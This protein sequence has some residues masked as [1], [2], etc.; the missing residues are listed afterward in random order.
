M[1]Y[2]FCLVL[3][4]ALCLCVCNGPVTDG[5]QGGTVITNG[6]AVRENGAPVE[7]AIVTAYPAGHSPPFPTDTALPQ[8]ITGKDGAFILETVAVLIINLVVIDSGSNSG[9]VL[10]GLT[11]DTAV[12]ALTLARFGTISGTVSGDSTGTSPL[13][14]GCVGTPFFGI[15]ASEG[16]AFVI[17]DIPPGHYNVKIYPPD[18]RPIFISGAICTGEGCIIASDTGPVTVVSDSVTVIDRSLPEPTDSIQ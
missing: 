2:S 3:A 8:A 7:G 11:G 9:N 5:D 10:F 15:V 1:R 4:T 14:T 6:Y 17:A 12:G 13:I 16:G 18:N